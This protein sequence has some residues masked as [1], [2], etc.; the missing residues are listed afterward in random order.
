MSKVTEYRSLAAKFR[1]DAENASLPNERAA[2]LAAAERWEA[3]A[4]ELDR[5]ERIL[6]KPLPEWLL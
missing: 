4:D 3:L 6:H 1:R 5:S 2:N